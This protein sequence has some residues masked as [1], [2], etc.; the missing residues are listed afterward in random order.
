MT[1]L[2]DYKFDDKIFTLMSENSGSNKASISNANCN[3]CEVQIRKVNDFKH[4]QFCTLVFCP[5][6]RF[7]TKVFPENK[8][9][10]RGDI[11]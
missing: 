9:M 8:N 3:C 2:F 7:K 4:C 1:A 6:C 11:C 5:K 10:D